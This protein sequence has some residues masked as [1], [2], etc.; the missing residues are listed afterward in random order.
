M[1]YC[2]IQ[3]VFILEKVNA[4][5]IWYDQCGDDPEYSDGRHK[6]NC[7]YQETAGMYRGL[8]TIFIQGGSE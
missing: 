7:V 3:L 4:N 1:I 2:F 5:C 6:L 8:G